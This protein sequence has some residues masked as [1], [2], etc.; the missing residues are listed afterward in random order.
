MCTSTFVAEPSKLVALDAVCCRNCTALGEVSHSQL[1]ILLSCPRSIDTY[2]SLD[3][4]VS[5][6]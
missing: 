5:L 1:P 6:L 4:K 2:D 3:M